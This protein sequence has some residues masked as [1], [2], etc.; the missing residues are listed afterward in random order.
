MTGAVSW[1]TLLWVI[2]IVVIAGGAVAGFLI[3]LY[4]IVMALKEDQ[5]NELEE[6]N[7]EQRAELEKR[8]LEMLAIKAE[9][10]AK[11]ASLAR[12]FSDYQRHV[13][14]TFVTKAGLSDAL[15]RLERTFDGFVARMDEGFE[16]LSTR[17][18]RLLDQRSPAPVRASRNSK[19]DL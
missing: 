7:K 11:A 2:G 18:D 10:A 13:G 6:R 17:I 15:T 8:D 9:T 14:E 12:E 4:R 3:T 19:D 5:K 1:E 16:R